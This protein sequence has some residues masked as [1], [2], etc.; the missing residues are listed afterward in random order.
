MKIKYW[1]FVAS[2][3]LPYV[4][5]GFFLPFLPD[6]IPMHYN[7]HGE[8]DRIGS[9]YEMLILPALFTIVGA[10][11]YLLARSQRKKQEYRN[12]NVIV[13]VSIFMQISYTVMVLFNLLVGLNFSSPIAQPADSDQPAETWL[14]TVTLKLTVIVIGILL[15]VM[16]NI[17]PKSSRNKSFG[18]RTTWS[19]KNDRV[20]Q[21]SQRFGGYS[22]ILCGFLMVMIGIIFSQKTVLLAATYLL[23][24]WVVICVIASY[25]FYKADLQNGAE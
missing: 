19:L 9:K 5:V 20:W 13:I 21:Q 23:L 22:G 8:M 16:G 1:I 10:A 2:L 15:I 24:V 25:R 4:L 17:M 14:T 6:Q 12:E 11:M 3:L 7:S 18:L